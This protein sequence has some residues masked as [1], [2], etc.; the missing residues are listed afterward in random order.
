MIDGCG[1]MYDAGGDRF[2]DR[3]VCPKPT[4][5]SIDESML[6]TALVWSRRSTC[7]RLAVGA[8]LA[9]GGRVLSCG[10]NGAPRG[11]EHCSH[12]DNEDLL[13]VTT[14]A[15]AVHAEANALISAGR[16]GASTDGAT[17]YCTHSPCTACASLMINA[18]VRAVVFRDKYRSDDGIHR[19]ETA[20]VAVRWADHPRFVR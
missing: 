8:V 5:P 2:I 1:C 4:R 15:T 7:S 12:V 19:L 3:C 17:I 10:Y 14:C 11:L 20:G 9:R 13:T 16:F 6:A 18:G